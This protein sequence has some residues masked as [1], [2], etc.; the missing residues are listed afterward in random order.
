M[1]LDPTVVI[2]FCTAVVDLVCSICTLFFILHN[3]KKRKLKSNKDNRRTS[4][5]RRRLS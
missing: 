5:N 3:N 1:K 4:A 2:S